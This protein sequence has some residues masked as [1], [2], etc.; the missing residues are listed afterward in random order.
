ME[1]CCCGLTWL[2]IKKCAFLGPILT[3]QPKR[4][5]QKGFFV[6]KM[7]PSLHIRRKENLRWPYL[8]N[9]FQQVPKL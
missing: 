3:T 2:G 8:E 4:K 5:V 7:D 9:N 6:E 1:I